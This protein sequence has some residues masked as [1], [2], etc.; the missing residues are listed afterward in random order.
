MFG[1]L[2]KYLEQDYFDKHKDD[3]LKTK[4]NKKYKIKIFA[5]LESQAT[6][7]LIFSPTTTSITE[8]NQYITK[9]AKYYDN[10]PSTSQKIIALSTC[11]YPD[12]EDRVI[13]FGHLEEAK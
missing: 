10:T 1:A 6:N 7:S 5:V 9:H 2:D 12:T 3:W 11:K 4:T 8:L 13:V